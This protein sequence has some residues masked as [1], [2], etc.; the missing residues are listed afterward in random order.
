MDTRR[1]R[2]APEQGSKPEVSTDTVPVELVELTSVG[3]SKGGPGRKALLAMTAVG[4]VA[5]AVLLANGRPANPTPSPSAPLIGLATTLPT[6]P[7]ATATL[8]PSPLRPTTAPSTP[9]PTP[10]PP[11]QWTRRD[12][13]PATQH[14]SGMWGVQDNILFLVDD[15]AGIGQYEAWSIMRLEN[16][17]ALSELAAP[18]AIQLFEGGS[19]IDDRLWF[20]AR[21]GAVNPEDATWQLVSTG[22]GEPWTSQGDSEGLPPF[23]GV[24]FIGRA[25]TN[26]VVATWVDNIA[27]TIPTISWSTDGRHWTRSTVPDLPPGVAFVQAAMF[28]DTMVIRGQSSTS[29]DDVTY[30]VLWSSDGRTWHRSSVAFPALAFPRDLACTVGACLITMRP[31]DT[32]TPSSTQVALRSTDGQHWTKL[33]IGVPAPNGDAWIGSLRAT[34]NGFVALGGA[35]SPVLLS[36]DGTKWRSVEVLPPDS[37]DSFEDFAVASDLVAGLVDI[38]SDIPEF[39][40]AGS[41]AAMGN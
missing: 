35:A 30:F 38:S 4:V 15:G 23:D 40:W 34:P 12:L 14:A 25:G 24:S 31:Y 3:P 39:A 36:T 19:V 5:I 13:W 27:N 33:T 1:R 8:R 21:V 41:L 29:V 9:R 32:D 37:A 20:L 16:E 17:G 26:L 7:P 28:G 22:D 18:P 6:A 11:W 2:D 10:P